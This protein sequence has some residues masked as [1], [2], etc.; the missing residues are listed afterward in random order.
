MAETTV[1]V[2]ADLEDKQP[3]SQYSVLFDTEEY[4]KEQMVIGARDEGQT[5]EQYEQYHK[6]IPLT[7]YSKDPVRTE[8]YFSL[9]DNDEYFVVGLKDTFDKEGY[10]DDSYEQDVRDEIESDLNSVG[11]PMW[12]AME[13]TFEYEGNKEDL[14]NKLSSLPN[15]SNNEDFVKEMNR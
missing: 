11:V 6:I 4:A 3:I 1:Y 8:F 15:W 12:E 5:L 9:V 13:S 14:V 7:L 10:L 2:I